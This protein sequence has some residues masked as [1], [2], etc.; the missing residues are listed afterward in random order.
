MYELR[1]EGIGFLETAPVIHVFEG[2]V[3][4]DPHAVFDLVSDVG[5][6]PRWFP[7]FRRGSHGDAEPKVG[8][9]REIEI[10]PRVRIEEHVAAWDRPHRY[11]YAVERTSVPMAKAL[12]EAWDL[13]PAEGGGTRVKWIF[14]IDPNLG[15]RVATPVAPAVMGAIFRAAL[16]RLDK[17]IPDH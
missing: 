10:F 8:T 13:A 15:M 14:A 9:P 2:D 1:D 12:V 7:G 5:S 6:W 3:G 4:G 17:I 16:R 11:A